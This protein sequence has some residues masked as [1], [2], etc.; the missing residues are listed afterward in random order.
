M[1]G[2]QGAVPSEVRSS[3]TIHGSVPLDAYTGTGT[4]TPLIEAY[5]PEAVRSESVD[6]Q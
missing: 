4:Q 3:G 1:A 2:F 5:A 6:D